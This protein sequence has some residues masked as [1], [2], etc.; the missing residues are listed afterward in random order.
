MHT[1]KYVFRLYAYAMYADK[2][3]QGI[4]ERHNRSAKIIYK[5][6]H[7]LAGKMEQ[8]TEQIPSC[9]FH[10]YYDVRYF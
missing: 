7:T 8:S 6:E 4:K 3:L 9:H 10:M 5:K 1:H 2:N